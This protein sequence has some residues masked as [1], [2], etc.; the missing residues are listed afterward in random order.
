[1]TEVDWEA[2]KFL[3]IMFVGLIVAV[4]AAIGTRPAQKLSGLAS[5]LNLPGSIPN[6]R[7]AEAWQFDP[8]DE[9]EYSLAEE[10]HEKDPNRNPFPSPIPPKSS[11]DYS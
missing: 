7:N 2:F 3:G 1:M 10:L 11:E 9:I 4:F 8:N 6:D 5:P